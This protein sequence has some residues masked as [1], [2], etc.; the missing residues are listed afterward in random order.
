MTAFAAIVRC[1]WRTVAVTGLVLGAT[2]A[3]AQLT[4]SGSP[5]RMRVLTA[6]AGFSLVAVT[7]A[8]T[9]YRIFSSGNGRHAITAHLNSP[10]PAGVTLKVDLAVSGGAESS[11]AV[12]LST[13]AR[14]VVTGIT[15]RTN[16]LSITYTLSATTAAGVVAFE[17]RSVTFTL[18]STP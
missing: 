14:N 5:A 18:I 4:V 8:S 12:T 9:T 1:I 17:T 11:G 10:M 2:D 16:D 15:K 3:G 13:M 7:N 6:T